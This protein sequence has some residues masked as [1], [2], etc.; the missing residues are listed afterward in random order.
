[1]LTQTADAALSGAGDAATRENM[2]GMQR[3]KLEVMQ[4]KVE[5]SQ[6][7]LNEM[8][9]HHYHYVSSLVEK[10]QQQLHEMQQRQTKAEDSHAAAAAV[11][12]ELA[13]AAEALRNDAKSSSGWMGGRKET[14]VRTFIKI[15][16]SLDYKPSSY[17]RSVGKV[18]LFSRIS[19]LGT[20]KLT[21]L[22]FQAI[23]FAALLAYKSFG[24]GRSR[25][26]IL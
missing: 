9:Y 26:K 12:S 19:A 24:G 15:D 23:F 21:F 17:T 20:P 6:E 22:V 14:H 16:L 4:R 5:A 10:S 3:M 8:Q 13:A 1:M 18:Y 11:K 7:Q 25:D 2:E